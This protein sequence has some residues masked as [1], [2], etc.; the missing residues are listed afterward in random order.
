M[1]SEIE[2]CGVELV[3]FSL[4]F[5]KA[6]ADDMAILLTTNIFLDEIAAH[7]YYY[8]STIAYYC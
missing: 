8:Y 4:H 3:M 6:V 7:F 2:N 5:L 1:I